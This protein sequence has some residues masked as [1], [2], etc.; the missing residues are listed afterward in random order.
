MNKSQKKIL[1]LL[2]THDKISPE[3][4]EAILR[5]NRK[6]ISAR[7]S[8]LRKL[9]YNITY[10]RKPTPH[11]KLQKAEPMDVKILR[12]LDEKNLWN[13]T[14]HIDKLA[15]FLRTDEETIIEGLVKIRKKYLLI[16]MNNNE[17][18]ISQ[19]Q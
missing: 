15:K 16:Q 6:S 1:H 8:E 14:L 5:Q 12:I 9:G 7:I 19:N 11:Y 3:N 13:T 2:E 4:L 18:I 10:K 17:V